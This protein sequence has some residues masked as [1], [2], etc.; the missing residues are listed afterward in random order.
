MPRTFDKQSE[1]YKNKILEP[2]N[3]IVTIEAGSVQSWQKYLG[4]MVLVSE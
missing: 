3:L 2:G 1:D 4:K